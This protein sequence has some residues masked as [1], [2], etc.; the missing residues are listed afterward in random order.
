M[1]VDCVKQTDAP[2][3]MEVR[4]SIL[5]AQ[6]NSDE[7]LSEVIER[8]QQDNISSVSSDLGSVRGETE[9][10]KTTH[11][12]RRLSRTA[13]LSRKN[14]KLSYSTPNNTNSL[15]RYKKRSKIT[16]M[17]IRSK[18]SLR[19]NQQTFGEAAI[20]GGTLLE[21]RT[22]FSNLKMDFDEHPFFSRAWV[23]NHPLDINSPLLKDSAKRFIRENN[24][25]W[26]YSMNNPNGIRGAIK[27]FDRLV[28]LVKIPHP[29]QEDHIRNSNNKL[30]FSFY[31]L[32]VL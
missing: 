4:R 29:K 5:S 8:G 28:S 18:P 19:I 11:T 10:I 22:S 31:L 20:E 32:H 15:K 23:V 27:N 12:D 24:G 2:Q 1:A 3:D 17:R 14:K 7:C 26:P 21:H 13:F 6:T 9:L 30:I 16:M 25:S